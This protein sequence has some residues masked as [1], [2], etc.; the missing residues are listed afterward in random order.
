MTK[1]EII[2]QSQATPIERDFLAFVSK[3]A[4]ELASN[5]IRN[6]YRNDVNWRDLEPALSGVLLFGLRPA[7]LNN[8]ME[9]TAL[10]SEMEHGKVSQFHTLISDYE[11]ALYGYALA[12]VEFA[13][14]NSI[15]YNK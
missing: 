6:D 8:Q 3:T 1:Y 10:V 14:E 5:R 13:L 9:L 15:N 7:W 12:L 11:N 4:R 2:A